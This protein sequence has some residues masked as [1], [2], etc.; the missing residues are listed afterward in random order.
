LID[1][2]HDVVKEPA[3]S[4]TEPWLRGNRAAMDGWNAYVAQNDLPLAAFRRF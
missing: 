1:G 3:A 4:K 2:A